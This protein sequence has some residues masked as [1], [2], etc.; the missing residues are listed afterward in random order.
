M[1]STDMCKIQT[2]HPIPGHFNLIYGRSAVGVISSSDS[3]SE[4]DSPS[5]NAD[6][7][8]IWANSVRD[9]HRPRPWRSGRNALLKFDASLLRTD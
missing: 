3:D 2:A 9:I 7:F 6:V 4:P 1:N 8:Y 5:K